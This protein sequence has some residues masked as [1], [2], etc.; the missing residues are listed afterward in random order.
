MQHRAYKFRIYPT[1]G[2]ENLLNQ[3]FGCVRF[4]WNHHVAAFNSFSTGGPNRVVSSK[5]LK[6]DEHLGFLN[7]VSAAALQQK[8]RDFDEFKKQFFN[9]KRGK[10]LGRPKFKRK[11]QNDAYRLPNQKFALDA[12]N[13]KIRL[14]KIGKVKVVLDRT[15]PDD[16]KFLSVTISKNS[17]NQFFASVLVEENIKVKAPT[18]NSIGIDLGFIDLLT[19]S[20]GTVI[21][22]PRWFRK[23][24]AKLKHSQRNLSRKIKG[25]TRYIKQRTRVAKVHLKT[26]RQRSWFHHQISSW[27]VNNFD[28]ICMEDLNIAGMKKMFGKSASD[29][30]LATLVSQ[31]QHKATWAGR[32]FHRVD[33]FFAS[34]KTCSHCGLKSDF[35]LG[36]REWTCESCG[37]VH[38]RDL[39]AAT[40]ILKRGLIDLYDYTP[41]ELTGVIERGE[42]VRP[43]LGA[44]HSL[45]AT[46]VKRL[47]E[48]NCLA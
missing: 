18:G 10:K 31:I 25:S 44:M 20:D 19:L 34:S 33:Q 7:S 41:A 4:L 40:N 23:N 21:N 47:A 1:K 22:N 11:G 24:Q 28:T 6:D 8:D 42:A 48:L 15:I 38:D 5:L 17:A 36:V 39:N 13:K 9:K 27:L 3:T 37:T 29:A 35:G 26:S 43:Q 2:Q 16:A 12:L 45:V 30:G 46:S 14:E 32:T